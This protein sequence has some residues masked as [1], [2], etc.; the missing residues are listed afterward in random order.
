M[1]ARKTAD[2]PARPFYD[3]FDGM[4]IVSVALIALISIG[5]CGSMHLQSPIAAPPPAPVT[6]A[7]VEAP[8]QTF[9]A[10]TSDTRVARV[11]DVREGLTKAAAFKAASDF[12]TQKYSIDV[13][14]PK[15]GFLMTPWINAMRNGV[16]DLRYRTRLVIRFLGDEGKQVA[17]RSEA[18]WQKGEEWDIG[19]D[20]QMLEDAVIELR[21]RIGKKA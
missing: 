13:S 9:V 12:L 16:P 11:I 19:F 1:T 8:P 15:A 10:T 17:V 18:N 2:S 5:A 20:T 14:D 7:P 6:T 21:T 4:K 3:S